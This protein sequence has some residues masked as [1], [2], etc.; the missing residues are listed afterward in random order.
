MLQEMG[1]EFSVQ[2]T[3]GEENY[4]EHLIK[5]KHAEY[6]SAQKANRLK[7]NSKE[8]LIIAADT[9][10]YLGELNLGKPADEIEAK[11]ILRMLSGKQHEVIT[12]ATIRTLNTEHTFSC[13]T[14]VQFSDFK[15]SDIDAY[16][17]EYKPLDKAGAYGIQE[18]ITPDGGQ[19]GPLHIERIEGSY[20]NV[21]GL[22]VE[23]LT[24]KLKELPT[25]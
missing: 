12:A 7:I 18:L 3:F 4:P 11:S 9:V 1:L 6:L 17:S 13:L 10:V 19:I 16:I 15:E 24:R 21:M 23:E 5:G 8:D 22:P 20:T 14:K 2:Q 25:Q